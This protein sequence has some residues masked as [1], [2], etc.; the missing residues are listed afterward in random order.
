M[1]PASHRKKIKRRGIAFKM[2]VLMIAFIAVIFTAIFMSFNF[3]IEEYIKRETNQQLSDAMY[4]ITNISIPVTIERFFGLFG[5]RMEV[6][7]LSKE[8]I[9]QVV[10][11]DPNFFYELV[12]R[13]IV[14]YLRTANF[15]AEV[16]TVLYD[17]KSQRLY[18]DETY[19]LFQNLDEIDTLIDNLNIDSL[20]KPNNTAYRTSTPHG[21]YYLTL[22]DLEEE[23]GLSGLSAALYV[24]TAKYDTFIDNINLTLLFILIVATVFSIVYVVFISK[25][26]SKPVQDLCNFAEEIGRGN[27]NRT[28]YNF[29]DREFI[30]LN[31]RMNETAQRLEKN[32]EDQKIFFQN[33]SHELKTPLMSIKGY[34]EG[35]K[36]GVFSGEQQQAEAFDIIISETDRLNDLVSDLLY[37]SKLDTL[38]KTENKTVVNLTE[39]VRDCA[40]K[41]RGLLINSDKQINIDAPEEIYIECDENSLIRAILN[42][43]ANCVQYAN[44]NIDVSIHT[45]YNK[46]SEYTGGNNIILSVKDDGSGIDENDLPNIF[47]RFYKGKSGKHGIGLA[48]TKA[49]VEQHGGEIY[50]RNNDKGVEFVFI[51]KTISN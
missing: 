39:L 51:L 50:A 45:D 21:N 15:D 18:P 37:I 34:A 4:G 14:Q 8:Q 20:T 32:D 12:Y 23:Y 16:N 17:N 9:Q 33:V 22:I 42:V 40:E 44:Y 43:I 41:V 11:A 35:I 2:L 10:A 1:E 29:N 5:R 6:V 38:K 19:N 3:L 36:Y 27:F 28:D 47:K 24:N 31:N 48:I 13:E 7:E 49:I 30:D 26:I 25:N 46:Y